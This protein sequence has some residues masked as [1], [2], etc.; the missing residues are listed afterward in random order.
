MATAE[1]AETGKWMEQGT[2]G[3]AIWNVISSIRM[4]RLFEN[5]AVRTRIFDG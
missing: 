1:E 2:L 3:T 5:L 4:G